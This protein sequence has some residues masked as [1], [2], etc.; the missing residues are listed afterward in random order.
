MAH[1]YDLN[2]LTTDRNQVRL[3]IG[4]TR[5]CTE[6]NE[7][8]HDEEIDS[9]LDRYSNVLQASVVCCELLIARLRH[10]TS[11]SAVGIN[12]DASQKL[13]GLKDT[14][15][16]LRN[17]ANQDGVIEPFGGGYSKSA[18][19]AV[20]DDTDW[21]PIPFTVGMHDKETDN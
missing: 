10:K 4:D 11:R 17:R 20:I 21:D 16:V 13:D 12:E 5:D 3:N 15:D 19:Q 7:S 18:A 2:D 9:V 14:L 6:V 1:T 8:L